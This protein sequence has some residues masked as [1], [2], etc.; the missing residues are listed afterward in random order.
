MQFT[1]PRSSGTTRRTGDMEQLFRPEFFPF[2][3]VRMLQLPLGSSSLLNTA[4]TG[5][6]TPISNLS[7][8]RRTA[9]ATFYC[10]MYAYRILYVHE[11]N[12]PLLEG[13][14]TQ[15]TTDSFRQDRRASGR[16]HPACD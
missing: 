9:C 1:T 14:P 15:K 3:T 4:R 11:T 6:I 16:T 13:R 10:H 2:H 7:R 12:G 8:D 5:R